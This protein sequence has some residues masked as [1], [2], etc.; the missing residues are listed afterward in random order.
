MKAA[1]YY[2]SERVERRHD[3]KVDLLIILNLAHA[4]MTLVGSLFLTEEEFKRSN[5]RAAC[6]FYFAIDHNDLQLM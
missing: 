6:L 5:T 3:K 4:H 1:R 2:Y